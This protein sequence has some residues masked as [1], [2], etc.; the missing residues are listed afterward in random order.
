M[1]AAL[2]GDANICN[3]PSDRPVD[4]PLS[5]RFYPQ[6]IRSMSRY[7][8]HLMRNESEKLDGGVEQWLA[9]SRAHEIEGSAEMSLIPNPSIIMIIAIITEYSNINNNNQFEIVVRSTQ[10]ILP[11]DDCCSMRR[12]P[13]R[14]MLSCLLTELDCPSSETMSIVG[15]A[16]RVSR[17]CMR[18]MH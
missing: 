10:F 2:I 15:Y 16:S 11:D 17:R 8:Q 4:R 9:N 1:E 13:F 12:H 6:N 14:R 18:Q 5:G 3:I 7:P